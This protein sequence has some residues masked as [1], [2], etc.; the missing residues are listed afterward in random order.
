MTFHDLCLFSG[1]TV[2]EILYNE[3]DLREVR[4]DF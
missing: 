4:G 1:V 3:A 2:L